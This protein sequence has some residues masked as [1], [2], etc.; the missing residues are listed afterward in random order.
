MLNRFLK[1]SLLLLLPVFAIG[2]F[3]YYEQ[4]KDDKTVLEIQAFESLNGQAEQIINEFTYIVS[5]LMFLAEH[6][7]LQEFLNTKHPLQRQ[8]LTQEYYLFSAKKRLYDQ[9]RFLNESGLEIA[10]VNFNAGNPIIV[11]VERLQNKGKRYYFKDAFELERNDVFI[12][13]FDLNIEKGQ[14]ERPLKPMIRFGT[15]IFDRTGQKRGIV[16]LNYLGI[17]LLDK[18]AKRAANASSQIMLLN[19]DG[20]WLKSPVREDEWGFMYKD[21]SHKTFGHQYSNEWEQIK[22][23]ESGQFTTHNGIFT[24]MTI[25]PLVEGQKSSTGTQQAFAPSTNLLNALDYYWKIVAYVSPSTLQAKSQQ[26]LMNMALPFMGIVLLILILAAFL[27]RTHFKHVQAE[28]ALRESEERFKAIVAAIPI[29]IAI[30]RLIDNT[31]LYLNQHYRQAFKLPSDNQWQTYQ[32]HHLYLNSQEWQP[33]LEQLQNQGYVHNVELKTKP[34]LGNP[35]CMMASF[36]LMNFKNETAIISV[37]NDITARKQTEQKIQQQKEFLQHIIDSLDY[38]FYV[39][40][41]NNYQIILANAAM[42]ALEISTP[43]ICYAVTH[44][45]N[46]PCAGANDPCP[47]GMVKSTKKPVIVEHSHFD[48]SGKLRNVEVRGFPLFDEQGNITQMIEYSVDITDRKLAEQALWESERRY[49]QMFEKHSSIHLLVDPDSARIIDANPAAAEFYGYPLTKLRQMRV[50]DINTLPSEAVLTKLNHIKAQ[51]N[52]HFI[53]SHRLASGEIRQV[54]IYSGPL[55]VKDHLLIYAV[56]HDVTQRQQTEAKLQQQNEELQMQNEQLDAFTQQLETMQQQKLYQLNKAYERFVP[57]EFL[58][59]LEKQSILE[60]QLGDHVEKEITILF[61]DIRRFT[62][63]SEKMTP[64]E[65]F[66]FINSYLSRMEPIISQNGGFIDKYIGDAIMALFPT[67]ADDAVH[68]AIAI[69]KQLTIYNQDRQKSSYQPLTI[70]IGLNTGPSMLGTVGGITRMD[71]TVI[72]DAVNLASRVEDLTKI[73]G[74]PLLITEQT[75]VKLVDPLG[76]HIRVIDAVKVKGK[77]EKITVYEIYDADSPT[78]MSLKDKTRDE[79]E[80][81]FVLYHFEEFKDAYPFFE[82]VLQINPNDQVAQIY[83]KRCLHFQK[84]GIPSKLT[85]EA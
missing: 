23:T 20:F 78:I 49:R 75:Y 16:L 34:V 3:L 59:L 57:R 30:T 31:F 39:I 62:S 45:R 68:G 8:Q 27:N 48:K 64:Q 5:D 70:G 19:T 83:S 24:F 65:N 32:A 10:R 74:T 33:I 63:L 53:V 22:Q 46:S 28:V 66:N 2:T 1:I 52:N 72:S 17:R 41:V 29:P 38:P 67:C 14:I 43:A 56:I 4:L 42:K 51:P 25:Y 60:V 79:F 77:L 26:I 55:E 35:F 9:I 61:S 76:Y 73:Y 15:P 6:N 80:E 18:M 21:S 13:P 37:F 12:S 50:S 71:G 85:T 54:E 47:L 69:L 36:Q 40:D 11:P 58:A 82:R 7:E 81:G 44:H 84:N